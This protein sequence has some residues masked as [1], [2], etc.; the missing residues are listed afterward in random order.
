M[1]FL[2]LAGASAGYLVFSRFL[3]DAPVWSRR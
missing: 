3:V 1:I 2:G